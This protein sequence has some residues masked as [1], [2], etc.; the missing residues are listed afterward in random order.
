MVVQSAKFDATVLQ[1]RIEANVEDLVMKERT[2]I[3]VVMREGGS[4]KTEECGTIR[5]PCSSEIWG[6]GERKKWY[7]GTVEGKRGSPKK[8]ATLVIRIGSGN[9]GNRKD[10]SFLQNVVVDS[11]V[12][13]DGSG[14]EKR[15][16]IVIW[17]AGPN[18]VTLDLK[19]NWFEETEVKTEDLKRFGVSANVTK[20]E[21]QEWLVMAWKG[22]ECLVKWR[23]SNQKDS[24]PQDSAHPVFDVSSLDEP[25]R[26]V[27]RIIPS[28]HSELCHAPSS[29]ALFKRDENDT[30]EYP[31]PPPHHHKTVFIDDIE[32]FGTSCSL[33]PTLHL[34]R[35]L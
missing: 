22:R 31:L 8:G 27:I 6:K 19:G 20:R 9:I 3:E 17:C 29:Q 14:E 33:S 32:L 21:V 35:S 5:N 12:E 10:V 15:G 24:Q 13:W 25:S 16:G 28:K 7:C 30:T 2:T 26:F 34:I 1:S 18:Q 11:N 4:E 23:E